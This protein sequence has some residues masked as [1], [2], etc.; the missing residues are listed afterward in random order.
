MSSILVFDRAAS[1]FGMISRFEGSDAGYWSFDPVTGK[2]VWHPGWEVERLVDL[3]AAI[4]V[5]EIAARFKDPGLAE[6]I[7]MPLGTFV[8]KELGSL[9]MGAP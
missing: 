7:A 9:P 1:S 2:L 3:V 5:L 4:D 8:G 6:R